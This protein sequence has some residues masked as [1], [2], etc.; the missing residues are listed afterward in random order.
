MDISK[1]IIALRK[2]KGVTQEQLATAVNI[3]PQAVSKWETGVSLPDVQTLPLIAE[4]FEVSVDYLYKGKDISYSNLDKMIFDKV[5]Q[6][7]QMSPKSY[8]EELSL[9]G[10]A[11]HGVFRGTWQKD[12]YDSP[13]PN[14]ISNANGLSLLWSKGF[15]AVITR[16][17]FE[18]VD[19]KTVN[20]AIPLLEA[21][22]D[23]DRLK[24]VM[25]I[26]S[27][28]EISIYELAERLGMTEEHLQEKL[29]VLIRNKI[30]FETVSKHKALGTTYKVNDMYHTGLCILLAAMETT[31]EGEVNG[32]SCCMGYGDYPIN[33]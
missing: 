8:K 26:V 23:E 25:A 31:R 2:K 11:H 3:S 24:I 1:N 14:H 13:C 32:I 7:P 17:F 16:D 22:A 5:A 27:M 28:D 29:T 9:F 30:V 21:L 20:F 15:G 4:Y 18:Q 10:A 33:L 12:C 6:H 19:R